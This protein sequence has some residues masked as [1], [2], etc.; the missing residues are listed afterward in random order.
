MLIMQ[1][2]IKHAPRRYARIGSRMHMHALASFSYDYHICPD[3]LW[4]LK[5]RIG[6]Y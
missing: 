4:N 3:A 6:V 5:T 1:S 2:Q